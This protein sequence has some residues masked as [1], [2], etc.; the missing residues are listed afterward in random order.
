V[1]NKDSFDSQA[2]T[3]DTTST[4]DSSIVIQKVRTKKVKHSGMLDA[5]MAS[6]VFSICPNVS[7]PF[8]FPC[9]FFVFGF[10]FCPLTYS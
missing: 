1:D 5:Y 4:K 6:K 10:Q 2:A 8:A 7:F 3:G 9:Q